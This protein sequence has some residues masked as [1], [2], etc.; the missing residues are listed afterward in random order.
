MR[1]MQTTTLFLSVF[2]LVPFALAGEHPSEFDSD[3]KPQ[4]RTNGS[5]VVRQVTIHD[6]VNP[7]YVGDVLVLKGKIAAVGMV[8]PP[9]GTLEVDGKGL[10][11]APGVVD[12][13]SHIAIDGGVNEGSVS[14]SA[15]VSIEDVVDPKDISIWRALGG[16]VTTA[17]LLHGSANT[18]GGQDEVIKL[19]W[20]R[21]ADELRFP[22]G[23]RGIKF[24]LGENPKRSNGGGWGS[25]FP[26]TRMGVEAVLERAFA[27]AREYQAEWEAYTLAQ[28]RGEDP[29]P[30]RRDLRLEALAGILKRDI[31]VHSHCYRADEILM[32]IRVAQRYGFAIATLQHVLEAYKVAPEMAAAGIAGS[33]FSDWWAYKVEAYD[34]IPQNAALMDEAGISSSLNSDS[35]EMMRHLYHEAAKSVRYAGM[36]RVRALR[37]VTQNAAQQ[38]G[39]GDR[40][41]SIEVGKD[42][43]LVLL[44]GDPLS[45]YARVVWTMVDG[46]IEFQRRDAFGLDANPPAIRQLDLPAIE[47]AAAAPAAAGELVAITNAILH[48]VRAPQIENGTVLIQGGKIQA[49]GSDIEIPAGARVVDAA[50]RHVY[51]GL[52][53]LYTNIG[54]TEIGSVPATDDQSERGGNQ[55]DLRT[56]TAIHA[57]S[58]HIAVTR[59]NGVTRAQVAPRG[60]GPLLG[61]SAVM[62]LD[63]SHWEELIRVDRDMLHVRFPTAPNETKDKERKLSEG[64]KE[65]KKLFAEAR[66][67]GRLV[68]LAATEPAAR[69]EYEPRLEALVP[70]VRGQKTLALHADNAQTILDALRF[71]KEESLQVVIYGASEGWKVAD[72]LAQEGRSV[73][74]GPV[75]ALPSSREDPYDA[76]YANAAVMARA[77]VKLAIMTADDENPRNLAFH[78]AMAASFGL[79]REE[80]LRA[81]TLYPAQILGMDS[82]VG[83][84]A[85]GM[86]ADLIITS[87]DVLE[88]ATTVD[89]VFIQGR[90][91]DL[92]NRQ[93]EL[94][95]RYRQRML[96][97]KSRAKQ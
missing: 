67:Y 69:P 86:I 52:I 55:P 29:A 40:V 31:L 60:G 39:I 70:Y 38:L 42:A 92:S 48:P 87:G 37:L 10:H 19:K 93:S 95:E 30:P 90:Q 24:A 26:S 44:N 89:Y 62:Q 79:P 16:G 36:D 13:H 77:G 66:E 15:E 45:S 23:P 54:M 72:V 22:T 32:L 6:A 21:S 41:G 96:A 71:A 65:L 1:A 27:R 7:A 11:L 53:A 5:C 74:V 17:R 64:A 82:E 2:A 28:Q 8:S 58:A 85:P 84:L 83:S 63:G 81:I 88:L 78:A 9:E 3:R 12:C 33:T 80:A 56:S 18:I 4:L 46:E 50:G 61:Q 57:D 34:G 97:W 49:M 68:D 35:D 51:P 43:D 94:Y 59:T 14:I 76:A 75:L 20:G 91:Q 73:V 47:P 25:R